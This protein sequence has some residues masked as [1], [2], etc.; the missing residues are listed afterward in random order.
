M[1]LGREIPE[2]PAPMGH[3]QYARSSMFS[4]ARHCQMMQW[5]YR[6]SKGTLYR[7][8]AA[9][10]SKAIAAAEEASG[11]KITKQRGRR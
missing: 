10:S 11:E 2:L 6:D 8:V 4:K 7:G 9:S 1:V 5:A 3:G